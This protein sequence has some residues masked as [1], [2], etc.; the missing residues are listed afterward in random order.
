MGEGEKRSGLAGEVPKP[1]QHGCERVGAGADGGQ[2]ASP[3]GFEQRVL[4]LGCV[5]QTMHHDVEAG[6]SEIRGQSVCQPLNAHIALVAV[7][8]VR[9][10]LGGN[11]CGRVVVG[12][13]GI[14]ALEGKLA[15]TG[16]SERSIELPSIEHG[17][18]NYQ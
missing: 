3:A 8:L 1:G 15:A 6:S 16:E 5:G 12:V 13:E 17:L 7:A 2:V 11:V 18:K 9:L 10:Y 4:H 14:D